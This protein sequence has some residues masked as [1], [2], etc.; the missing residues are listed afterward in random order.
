MTP[1]EKG[2]KGMQHGMT[3]QE[4]GRRG[5]EARWNKAREEGGEG[6]EGVEE[7]GHEEGKETRASRRGPHEGEEEHQPMS[8]SER[9]KKGI[10]HGMSPHDRGVKGAQA[11]WA[12]A[13]PK[14]EEQGMEE[15]NVQAPQRGA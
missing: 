9:G 8:P 1:Q 13:H 14:S 11:R 4:R 10:S 7:M 2:H 12:K 5:A 15:T 3:P 6:S